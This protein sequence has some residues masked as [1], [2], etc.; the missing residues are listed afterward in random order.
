MPPVSVS[1]RLPHLSLFLALLV[2]PPE[3]D[4]AGHSTHRTEANA[5]P[6]LGSSRRY[7]TPAKLTFDRNDAFASSSPA[8]NPSQQ[9]CS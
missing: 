7:F 5:A 8:I 2:A 9:S 3:T 1:L 4:R 6:P